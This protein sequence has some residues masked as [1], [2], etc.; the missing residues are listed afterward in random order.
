MDA[1]ANIFT[2]W[3]EFFLIWVGFGTIVG[4][5]AK[6]ILPGRDAGGAL[7]TTLIGVFGSV[8]G[9]ATLFFFT[10]VK[11]SPVSWFGFPTA[12]LATTILL[13]MY[14]LL[15]SRSNHPLTAI[16]RR[17]AVRRRATIIEE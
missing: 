2:Q 15:S 9:A 5:I 7:A 14:R 6:A 1:T 4:L 12:L 13:C 3:A 11:V 17:T 8:I 10:G 16:F